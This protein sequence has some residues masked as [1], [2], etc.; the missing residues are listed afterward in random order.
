MSFPKYSFKK[1][2]IYNKCYIF[3]RKR[4]DYLL[5]I[6]IFSAPLHNG[7]EPELEHLI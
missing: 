6:W 5:N 7:D 3:T 4:S 2:V 1:L